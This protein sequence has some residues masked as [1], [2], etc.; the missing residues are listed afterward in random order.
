MADSSETT[1]SP[2]QA[3]RVAVVAVFG[4]VWGAAESSLGAILRSAS[5]PMHGTLMTG[6]GILI[7]LVARRAL[8]SDGQ[9]ARGT[10]MAVAVVAAAIVPLSVT[11]GMIWAMIGIV[12]AGLCVEAV[13]WLGRP[14]RWR[15][16]AAG[17]L[18]ALLPLAQLLI[19]LAVRFGPAALSTFRTILL[20]KQGGARLGL[21]GLTT[22]VLA[23][24]IFVGSAVYGLVC[25]MAAWS[26]AQQIL[27]RLGREAA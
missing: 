27:K 20:D 26:L 22:G 12:A 19:L 3:R 4:A 7:M 21:A 2:V 18:A 16:G 15:F 5:I 9:Q 17:L 23:I 6:I 8:S 24:L 13:L 14:G 1:R 25:G 11:R 10:S